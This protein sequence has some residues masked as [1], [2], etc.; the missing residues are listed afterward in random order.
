[1]S[2]TIAPEMN[3]GINL[4]PPKCT[5]SIC[6]NYKPLGRK[7][8]ITAG[9]L[10]LAKRSTFPDFVYW[11]NAIPIKC[12]QTIPSEVYKEWQKA[13][14]SQPNIEGRRGGGGREGG[15]AAKN[16]S[17]GLTSPAFKTYYQATG[18]C[19]ADRRIATKSVEE[20]RRPRNRSTQI[21]SAHLW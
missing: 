17:E 11:F 14:N 13:E 8:E 10:T 21:E 15:E 20:T 7:S 9:T 16:K 19:G 5:G 4:I 1:M 18:Q 2:F 3:S 6:G 12:Q